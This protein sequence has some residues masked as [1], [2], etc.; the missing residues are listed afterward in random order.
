MQREED[1]RGNE[2][3]GNEE[4]N[5]CETNEREREAE[6]LDCALVERDDELVL[7]WR[8]C[9]LDLIGVVVGCHL[10]VL[11]FLR[12]ASDAAAARRQKTMFLC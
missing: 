1:E 11:L 5:R 4:K 6:A 12:H 3:S 9:Y 10:L 2:A 7:L 8:E